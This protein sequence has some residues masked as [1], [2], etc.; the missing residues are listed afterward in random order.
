MNPLKWC[1]LAVR[2]L[3]PSAPGVRS[4]RPVRTG[5]LLAAFALVAAA[6]AGCDAESTATAALV[7]Q[8]AKNYP[9]L[10]PTEGRTFVSPKLTVKKG[11][12]AMH[13]WV[14]DWSP[15]QDYWVTKFTAHQGSLGHH[16]VAMRSDDPLPPGKT[17]ECSSVADMVNLR[18]LVL[19]DNSTKDSFQFLPPGGAVKLAKGTSIVFQSH[20]NNYGDS[21]IEIQDAASLNFT[22]ISPEMEVNYVLVNV[23]SIAILP[24]ET[25]S[26]TKDCEAPVDLDIV[27][28]TGHMHEWGKHIEVDVVPGDGSKPQQMYSVPTWTAEYRD[29]PPVTVLHAAGKSVHVKAGDKIRVTCTWHNDTAKKIGYPSEMCTSVN[30]YT[31]KNPKGLILCDD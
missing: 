25:T 7:D 16:I 15:D 23:S 8:K 31:S 5:A 2:R 18:P 17:W 20:Y 27:A 3:G 11:A 1:A 10:K 12:D 6:L 29:A 28:T 21:D 22:A 30:Y 19:P 26:V 14:P 24:G 13:C 4:H 9:V